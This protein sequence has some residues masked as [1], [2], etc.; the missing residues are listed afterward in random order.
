MGKGDKKTKR[1]KIIQGSYGVTRKRARK[2]AAEKND[3]RKLSVTEGQVKVKAAKVVA[4]VEVAAETAEEA[5]AKAAKKK[6]AAKTT[7]KAKS[8]EEVAH[9]VETEAVKEIAEEP[10]KEPVAETP[11]T[12][13][14]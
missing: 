2:L 13:E 10:V 6:A 3:R 14:A 4:D 5:L 8:E 1:G 7:K 12:P 11:E 9:Q